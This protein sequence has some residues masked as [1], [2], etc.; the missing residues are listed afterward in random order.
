MVRV[1]GVEE[2]VCHSLVCENMTEDP[3]VGPWDPDA[4]CISSC[5]KKPISSRF[6]PLFSV[7][8]PN[9]TRG[10][11][12]ACFWRVDAIRGPHVGYFLKSF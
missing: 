5:P 12:V 6:F 7:F 3:Q 2:D 10:G 9:E 11:I 1:E 4:L 8:G